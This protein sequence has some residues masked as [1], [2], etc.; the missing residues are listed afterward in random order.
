MLPAAPL[1]IVFAPCKT[2]DKLLTM[3]GKKKANAS[4]EPTCKS[5]PAQIN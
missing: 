2:L 4:A 3:P 1:I 5:K